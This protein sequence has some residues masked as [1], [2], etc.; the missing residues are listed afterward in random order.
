MPPAVRLLGLHEPA[1][2]T[3]DGRVVEVS[4]SDERA[5]GVA[6]DADLSALTAEVASLRAPAA[7]DRLRRPPD[8]AVRP[9]HAQ[10]GEDDGEPVGD[11][12]LRAVELPAGGAGGDPV[13][14]RPLVA[15]ERRRPSDPT[16]IA[17]R[18]SHP[19]VVR[20]PSV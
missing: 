10:V 13:S 18:R 8:T 1:D 17:D 7:K 19:R 6:G 5:D 14:V 3:L 20:R 11:D 4:E 12:V 16:D 15:E 2:G 9:G